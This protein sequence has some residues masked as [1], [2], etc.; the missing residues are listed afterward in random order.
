MTGGATKAD[1]LAE[2]AAKCAQEFDD[3]AS[4]LER[5]QSE[6]RIVRENAANAGLTVD[7]FVINDPSEADK[8]PAYATALNAAAAAQSIEEIASDTLK[9]VWSDISSKWFFVVGDL[10]N[11]AAGTLIAAHS[12]TL[13]KQSKFL[14]DESEKFLNLAK[15]A[16]PGTTAATVYR[17]FDASRALASSADD[18]AKAAASAESTAGRLG[19]KV[20]GALAIGGIAYDVVNGKDVDQAIVSGGVGFGASVLARAAIGTAIPVP[21]VG[22]AVGALGG[23]VVGIFASGAVDSLYQN[24]IGAVGTAIDDGASAVAEAG[25]AVGGLAEDVWDAIF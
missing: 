19:L 13:L 4:E 6:M 25:K 18:A 3:F 9:N 15:T 17:D 14:A 20:G 10:I 23:A 1:G 16:P 22:T 7:G 8:Y 21:V 2:A 11:G 24:G 12:S 5:A